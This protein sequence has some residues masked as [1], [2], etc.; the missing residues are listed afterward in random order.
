MKKSLISVQCF[1]RASVTDDKVERVSFELIFNTSMDTLALIM[2]D[3]RI[4]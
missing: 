2:I 3:E 1:R 4:W